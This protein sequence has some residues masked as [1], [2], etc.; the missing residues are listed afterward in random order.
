MNKEKFK[1]YYITIRISEKPRSQK[2]TEMIELIKTLNHDYSNQYYY[3]YEQSIT[4]AII[5]LCST[6]S[7]STT[8]L[9]IK[10]EEVK[11]NLYNFTDIARCTHRDTCGGVCNQ[12]TLGYRLSIREMRLNES[13]GQLEGL[14]ETINSLSD[15]K[16]K[17][18]VERFIEEFTALKLGEIKE[19]V[20]HI[21]IKQIKQYILTKISIYELCDQF[22]REKINVLLDN[23]KEEIA[24]P[25]PKEENYS[26]SIRPDLI[27]D[28]DYSP[29][30]I[31][32]DDDT[33]DKLATAIANK[34]AEILKNTH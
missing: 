7:W 15:L 12:R 8:K 22:D 13:K 31:A 21:D 5:E 3:F 23:I 24:L 6:F 25:S 2:R 34:L 4:P 14:V 16:D 20:L 26:L 17:W 1:E 9:W 29:E 28:I 11:E 30:V 18:R 10:G 32:L 33:I 27:N 19:N